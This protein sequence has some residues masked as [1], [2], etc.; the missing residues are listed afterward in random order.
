MLALSKCSE[1]FVLDDLCKD[2]NLHVY[3]SR[4]CGWVTYS[5]TKGNQ[6]SV[7]HFVLLHN[8]IYVIT[9]KA[10]IGV[11]IVVNLS[12]KQVRN[13]YKIDFSTMTYVKLE[14]LGDIA[15]F[16]DSNHVQKNCYALSNPNR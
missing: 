8:I 1:E 7:V 3:Q 9:N 14:T 11:L 2:G 12:D 4:I 13:A 6:E 16:Y 15:L 10:N 5:S